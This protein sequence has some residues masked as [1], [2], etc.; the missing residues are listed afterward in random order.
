LY[1]GTFLFEK[2]TTFCDKKL[3]KSNNNLSLIN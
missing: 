2:I 1:R 3:E